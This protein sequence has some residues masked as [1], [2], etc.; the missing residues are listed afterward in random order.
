MDEHARRTVT[1]YLLAGATLSQAQSRIDKHPEFD[2]FGN[3]GTLCLETILA[4]AASETGRE[5]VIEEYREAGF[6][7][8]PGDSHREDDAARFRFDKLDPSDPFLFEHQVEIG[9]RGRELSGI[10]RKVLTKKV[11]SLR[12]EIA[13]KGLEPDRR[14]AA[15]QML[16]DLREGLLTRL[17]VSYT[18]RSFRPR[19]H[20]YED[21]VLGDLVPLAPLSQLVYRVE[22]IEPDDDPEPAEPMYITLLGSGPNIATVLFSG[23][24]AGQRTSRDLDG[25]VAHHAWFQNR[26]TV[27]TDDTA[28]WLGRRIFGE[29]LDKG[30][31]RM[32]VRWERDPEPIEVR[33]VGEEDVSL[34]VH[35]EIRTVPTLL[36]ETAMG[37]RLRILADRAS[38]LVLELMERGAE[39]RRTIDEVRSIDRR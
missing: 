29:L 16:N 2:S 12:G 5:T 24:I 9:V 1:P 33:R 17:D 4:G 15:V 10:Q 35:G 8:L 27:S 26:Q 23:G 18:R 11:E 25:G 22:P 6:V 3:E 32:V 19:I 37:D 21:A 34:K 13:S 30:E 28:P 31:S 36:A 39:L 7:E 20:H 38:P 14:T